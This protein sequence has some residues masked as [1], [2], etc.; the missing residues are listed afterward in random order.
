MPT[1]HCPITEFRPRVPLTHREGELL[2]LLLECATYKE[3]GAALGC[4]PRTAETYIR[5]IADK[6]PG[7]SDPLVRAIRYAVVDAMEQAQAARRGRA[8]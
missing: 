8:A 3:L 2:P 1:A 7:A 4:S 6:L 5:R